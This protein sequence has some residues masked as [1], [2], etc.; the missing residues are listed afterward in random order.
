[1]GGLLAWSGRRGASTGV[2]GRLEVAGRR[3]V[4]GRVPC[5][6]LQSATLAGIRGF[7][8]SA[9]IHLRLAAEGAWA[10]AGECLG[11]SRRLRGEREVERERNPLSREE[12]MGF[13]PFII[14]SSG[15]K[16]HKCLRGTRRG[17]G[18][19]LS[20]RSLVEEAKNGILVK[21]QKVFDAGLGK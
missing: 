16:A 18:R 13:S 14:A 4:N 11:C 6:A 17:R 9:R 20:L 7:P 10:K 5:Q 1:M 12:K 3:G 15:S 19:K 8:A 2:R 21:W